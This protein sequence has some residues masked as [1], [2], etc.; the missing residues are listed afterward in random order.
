MKRLLVS[1]LVVLVACGPSEVAMR[2]PPKSPPTVP[3]P[4]PAAPSLSQE[5]LNR[6][7]A[8][9]APA[10]AQDRGSKSLVLGREDYAPSPAA[11][12]P[13]ADGSA[14]A[15][16]R[17]PGA[18]AGAGAK[19]RDMFAEDARQSALKSAFGVNGYGGARGHY[20][21]PGLEPPRPPG[22]PLPTVYSPAIDYNFSSSG[23][24]AKK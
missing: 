10:A 1:S 19:P 23:Q 22:A 3:P 13:A 9:P 11:G 2:R 16:G 6:L 5:E 24:P 18:G 4:G 7:M 20:V 8:A 14:A 15:A 12:A 17:Q 21:Q